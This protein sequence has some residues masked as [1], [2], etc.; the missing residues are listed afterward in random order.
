ML[1]RIISK[2]GPLANPAGRD[3]CIQYMVAVPLIF[4]DLVAEHYENDFHAANP[5]IDALRQKMEIV[6]V[7]EYSAAYYDPDK[8]SIANAIQVFFKDGTSTE[9]V[10]VEYPIGHR[11]RRTEGIPLLENKFKRNLATRFPAVRCDKI[12]ELCKDQAKLEATPVHEFIGMFV[13]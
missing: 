10:L 8:R 7:D 4:G 6:E 11:R 12:F 3:H 1:V 2:I 9:D 13:I 5:L